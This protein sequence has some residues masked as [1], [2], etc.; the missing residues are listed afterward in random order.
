MSAEA[1]AAPPPRSDTRD[2][3]AAHPMTGDRQGPA[4]AQARVG[5]DNAIRVAKTTDPSRLAGAIRRAL[6]RH[7]TCDVSAAGPEA[8]S[9]AA[10]GIAIAGGQV[11]AHAMS[12]SCRIYIVST[13]SRDGGRPARCLLFRLER[14]PVGR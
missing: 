7:E 8:I 12:V 10:L 5:P 13:G 3:G 2:S 6:M 14:S 11:A 4:D 9:R 1:S